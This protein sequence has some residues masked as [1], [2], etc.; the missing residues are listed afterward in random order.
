[1]TDRTNVANNGHEYTLEILGTL[2]NEFRDIT[3]KQPD[4]FYQKN[5]DAKDPSSSSK[6]ILEIRTSFS[7]IAV[8]YEEAH[9]DNPGEAA[10]TCLDELKLINENLPLLIEQIKQIEQIEQIEKIEQLEAFQKKFTEF[11]NKE[12]DVLHK[13]NPSHQIG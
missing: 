12:E 13:L 9:S 1:M 5:A 6:Y 10:K 11:K 3:E 2:D 4:I 8:N 7:T